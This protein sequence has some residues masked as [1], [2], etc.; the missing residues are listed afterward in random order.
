[1]RLS[2]VC[3]QMISIAERAGGYA[4]TSQPA[5]AAA[6]ARGIIGNGRNAFSPRVAV[7]IKS[8]AASRIA[9][10]SVASRV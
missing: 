6:A 7:A 9:T 8:D 4:M 3:I 1:M 2:D 5:I 10:V